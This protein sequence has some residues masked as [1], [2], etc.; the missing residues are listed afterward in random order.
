MFIKTAKVN[1]AIENMELMD[2]IQNELL[3]KT[4]YSGPRD[5][6][7]VPGN[8]CTLLGLNINSYS[9]GVKDIWKNAAY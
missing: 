8:P 3:F 9:G 6:T 4:N 7:T 5:S 2:D 1:D